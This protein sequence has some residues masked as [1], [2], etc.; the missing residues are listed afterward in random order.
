MVW[1]FGQQLCALL[2]GCDLGESEFCDEVIHGFDFFPYRIKQSNLKL[3]HNELERNSW[4]SSSRTDVE[5][6]DGM[7]FLVLGSWFLAFYT[8]YSVLCTKYSD[9]IE[10]IHKVLLHNPLL[11]TYGREIGVTIVCDKKFEKTFELSEFYV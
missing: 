5:E 8:M 6:S 7:W 3:W 9:S 2:N 11:I 10:T 4:K 1:D